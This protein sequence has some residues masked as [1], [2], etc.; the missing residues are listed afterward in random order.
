MFAVVMGEGGSP[1]TRLAVVMNVGLLLL[2]A[3]SVFGLFLVRR[4]T[5]W[6]RVETTRTARG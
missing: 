2:A 6:L 5:E 4:G 3:L 1:A